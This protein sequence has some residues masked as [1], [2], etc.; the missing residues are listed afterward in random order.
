MADHHSP[1]AECA[2][3][4]ATIPR[5]AR[6]CPECGADERSGW[7]DSSVYDGL[8]LPDSAYDDSPLPRVRR[9][10]PWYWIATAIVMIVAALFISIGRS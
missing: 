4:G 5:R 7:R 10:L 2:N 8:D 3:C 6:S 9:G 1:P